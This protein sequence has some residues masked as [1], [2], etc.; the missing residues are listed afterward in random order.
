[1]PGQDDTP[2][3][4]PLVGDYFATWGPLDGP[5][6]RRDE[7]PALGV[8]GEPGGAWPIGMAFPV[9]QVAHRKGP[10]VTFRLMIG[11]VDTVPLPDRAASR[12]RSWPSRSR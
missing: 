12:L 7:P 3:A 11:K 10:A 2:L 6:L 1:M 5:I 4:L 9:G 8:V